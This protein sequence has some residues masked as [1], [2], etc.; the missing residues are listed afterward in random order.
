[1]QPGVVNDDLKAGIARHGLWY[2]PDPASAPWSTIGGNVATN[3]GGACCRKYGVTR[4][5]ELGMRA[6]VGGPV[7]HGTA[8]TLGRRTTRGVAGYEMVSRLVGSESTLGVVTEVTLQLRS[9]SAQQ[10]PGPH[11]RN[12]EEPPG[13]PADPTSRLAAPPRPREPA[14]TPSPRCRAPAGRRPGRGPPAPGQAEGGRRSISRLCTCAASGNPGPTRERARRDL[15]TDRATATPTGPGPHS[16]GPSQPQERRPRAL[17]P[18][19][20]SALDNP[21]PGLKTMTTR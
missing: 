10:R 18:R 8:V 11:R 20:R 14:A 16:D 13:Q 3:A 6:V 9:L 15:G 4:D 17:R 7:A 2:L 1:M 19:P 5:Y 21:W 12:R